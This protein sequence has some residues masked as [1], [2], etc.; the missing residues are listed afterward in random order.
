MTKHWHDTDEFVRLR[1]ARVAKMLCDDDD[2]RRAE[3]CCK[4]LAALEFDEQ[5]TGDWYHLPGYR[6]GEAAFVCKACA[7]HNVACQL[8]TL[9]EMPSE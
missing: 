3:H 9:S 7:V 8:L 2:P 6:N 5:V 1:D 4:H